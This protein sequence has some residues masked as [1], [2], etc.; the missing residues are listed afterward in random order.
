LSVGLTS[1]KH[2]AKVSIAAGTPVN[3]CYLLTI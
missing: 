1:G 3:V 2:L